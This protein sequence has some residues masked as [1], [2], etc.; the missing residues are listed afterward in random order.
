MSDRCPEHKKIGQGVLAD[1]RWIISNRGYANIVQS[2]GDIVIGTVYSI[3]PDDEVNLDQKEG[4]G[5]GLYCKEMYDIKL[6]DQ[7]LNC[8]VYVDR[9]IM[10]G[11]PKHEYIKRIND[12]IADA[13]L[14]SVYVKKYIRK[15]I[16]APTNQGI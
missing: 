7:F 15:F 12:G 13:C 3:T 16:P 4:V 1:Y 9:T 6:D 8:L 5:K 14:P 11:L 10:E 2:I